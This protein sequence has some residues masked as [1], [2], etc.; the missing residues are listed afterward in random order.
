VEQGKEGRKV[1]RRKLNKQT[2]EREK[3]EYAGTSTED[4]IRMSSQANFIYSQHIG[5]RKPGRPRRRWID[6]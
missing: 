5:R 1:T 4:A 6:V 2:H 3:Y